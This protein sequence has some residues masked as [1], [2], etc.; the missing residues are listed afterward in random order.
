MLCLYTRYSLSCESKIT[1]VSIIQVYNNRIVWNKGEGFADYF[2][3]YGERFSAEPDAKVNETSMV[4]LPTIPV[5]PKSKLWIQTELRI[6]QQRNRANL[7]F[8]SGRVFTCD[9]VLLDFFPMSRCSV[10]SLET[11]L[12]IIFLFF[13]F[14]LAALCTFVGHRCHSLF[15]PNFKTIEVKCYIIH[16]ISTSTI[17]DKPTLVV[18][19]LFWSTS[20]YVC[21]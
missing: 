16:K 2:H 6:S 12:W 19:S 5:D 9:N 10:S 15:W 4:P 3:Y 21:P 7:F 11:T 1:I 14:S 18:F 20:Y 13:F 17:S 8:S